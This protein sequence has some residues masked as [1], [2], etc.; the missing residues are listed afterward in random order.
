MAK[1][2]TVVA[3]YSRLYEE[4]DVEH[5]NDPHPPSQIENIIEELIKRPRKMAIVGPYIGTWQVGGWA[6]QKL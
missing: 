3:S 6:E 1:I 5:I 2:T 4:G